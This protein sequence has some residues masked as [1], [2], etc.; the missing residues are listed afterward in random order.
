MSETRRGRA[1]APARQTCTY[2]RQSCS[3]RKPRTSRILRLENSASF[4]P[5]GRVTGTFGKKRAISSAVGRLEELLSLPA[6][7]TWKPRPSFCEAK[8]DDLAEVA[9][10]DVVEDVAPPLA[11]VG[12]EAGEAV[13]FVRLDDVADPE[14]VDVGARAAL[15]GA[16]GHLVQHLRQAVAVHRVDVV[17]LLERQRLRVD[18]AVGEADAVGGLRGRD[19][20]LADAELHR[21]LDHVVGPEGVDAEGLVVGLDQDARDRGEMHDGVEGGDAGPGFEFVEAG[22]G[23]HRVEHLAGVGDVGDQ[24]VDARVVER[25]RSTFSTRWPRSSR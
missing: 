14:R 8:I 21:G 19:D 23:G 7:K 11:R 2:L 24:V 18:L 4:S 22:V 12:E 6:L 15:E 3:S 17:V 5:S 1:T 25:D 16:G 13:V 20:D 9:G 10:V